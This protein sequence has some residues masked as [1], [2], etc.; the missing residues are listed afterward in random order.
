VGAPPNAHTDPDSGLRFYRYNDRELIS[1]TS[2]RKVVGMPFGL[3]WWMVNQVVEAAS[4]QERPF[5]TTPDEWAKH[6]RKAATQKRDE[7]AAL[8]SEVHEAAEQGLKAAGME[9]LDPRLPFMQ[10]YEK[11]QREMSPTILVNEA[12]VFNLTLG[13]AGSLDLIAE[14][15]GRVTLIDLK[16]GKGV[17]TDHALQLMLYHGAEFIGGYD[18]VTDTDMPYPVETR[19]LDSVTDIAIL[20]LLPT[21]DYEWVPI[22]SSDELAAAAVDMVRFASF[23]VKHPTVETLRAQGALVP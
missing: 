6:L 5:A 18:P 3:A 11:W 13:Y 7:A 17:Y 19:I 10:A 15:A 23:L 8:G 21:G 14:V 22:L 1:A 2:I 20:H 12:Q 9:A 16:T 4:E